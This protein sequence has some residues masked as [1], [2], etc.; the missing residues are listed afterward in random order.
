MRIAESPTRL[1]DVTGLE[2]SGAQASLVSY[3]RPERYA[4]VWWHPQVLTPASCRTCGASSEPVALMTEIYES[5]CDVIGLTLEPHAD[6]ERYLYDIGLEYPVLSVS[7]EAARAHGV[8]KVPGE[9][10]PGI[11]HRVAYLVDEHGQVINRYEVGDPIAFLRSVRD[12]VKAGPPPS[13]W[14]PVKK[15]KKFLGIL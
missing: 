9:P 1:P 12:D 7:E 6:V 4:L 15:R 8:A 5:G 14:T 10:W 2:S 11:P 3:L 13:K